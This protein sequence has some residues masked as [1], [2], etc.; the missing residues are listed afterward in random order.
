MYQCEKEWNKEYQVVWL[1]FV[2]LDYTGNI[3]PREVR[4]YMDGRKWR[5]SK[6]KHQNVLAKD[7]RTCKFC[8]KTVYLY[9]FKESIEW[10]TYTTS[11]NMG[12]NIRPISRLCVYMMQRNKLSL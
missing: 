5:I 4:D 2:L 12:W 8:M 9:G 3:K 10:S 1:W 7:I 11:L 6:G